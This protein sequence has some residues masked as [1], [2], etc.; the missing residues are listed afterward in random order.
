VSLDNNI[1]L[2]SANDEQLEILDNRLLSITGQQFENE[3]QVILN[4]SKYMP[5]LVDCFGNYT[6]EEIKL[7][8]KLAKSGKLTNHKNEQFILYRELNF[9]SASDV[10]LAYEE[11][12]KDKLG[13]F[14]QNQTLFLTGKPNEPVNQVDT[15]IEFLTESWNI[16]ERN[17]V[18]KLRGAF[19][20]DY[21]KDLGLICLTDEEKSEIW[22][23][24]FEMVK[25]EKE[26]E[27]SITAD[28]NLYR[29]IESALS[30]LSEKDTEVIIYSKR[31]AFGYQIRNWQMYGFEINHIKQLLIENEN[32]ENGSR[33]N[34]TT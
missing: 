9:A 11:Y 21:F 28:Y 7:A 2:K 29:Q 14:I 30:K 10:L 18:D 20:Y 24:A 25:S 32:V 3:E 17:E 16:T 5:L 23:L 22:S 26:I 4:Y 33:R 31:I 15:V 34:S 19:L 27:K 13:A 8:Y 1:K 6:I 12:K